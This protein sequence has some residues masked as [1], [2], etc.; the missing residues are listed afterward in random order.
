MA[1]QA[2]SSHPLLVRAVGEI[3]AQ[4][5]EYAVLPSASNEAEATRKADSPRLFLLDACSLN[6]DLGPLAERCRSRLP[7]SKFLALVPP[8]DSDYA[9]ETRLFYWGIEGFVQLS[10][11]WGTELPRAIRSILN[12]QYWVPA[13]VLTAVVRHAQALEQTRLL[14][15]QSLTARQ[16]QVLRLLMRRLT[17]KEISKE[18]QISERTVKFHVSHILGKLG[19][20]DRRGLLPETLAR[21][22]LDRAA[23]TVDFSDLPGGPPSSGN[24]RTSSQAGLSQAG[25]AFQDPHTGFNGF[26]RESCL[27]DADIAGGIETLAGERMGRRVQGDVALQ[28]RRQRQSA[29]T[30]NV[31]R[32]RYPPRRRLP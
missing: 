4:V 13:E 12:G 25:R 7:D 18:L 19:L 8:S 28:A 9:D 14:P 20:E 10:D 23:A 16:G 27:A 17:N 5:K 22:Q 31:I 29:G 6:T 2:I 32:I 21:F 30:P 1:I 3:L 26:D 11:T 24:S 15:G